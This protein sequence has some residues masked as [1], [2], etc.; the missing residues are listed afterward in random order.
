LVELRRVDADRVELVWEL[1]RGQV[2]PDS[3]EEL[4]WVL[5]TPSWQGPKRR[6]FQK[7]IH[8]GR[9]HESL[10]EVPRDTAVSAAIGTVSEGRFVPRAV[11]GG[12]PR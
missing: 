6:S 9:G 10:L 5:F 3:F 8:P 1:T 4:R 7:R 12:L 2:P 11:F